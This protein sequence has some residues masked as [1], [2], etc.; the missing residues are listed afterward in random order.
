MASERAASHLAP[1]YLVAA[2]G[3][4][5][6]NFAGSLV[7]M[8][9]HRKAGA[10]GFVVNRPAP[11]TVARMLGSVDEALGGL[12]RAS[13]LGSDPVLVGGPVSPE[14]V[15]LLY[16]R[17]AAGEDDDAI[18]VGRHL[19]VASSRPVLEAILRG[20]DAGPVQ[21]FVG[22]A[23]WAPLQLEEEISQGSW[24]PLGFDED[25]A[26]TIPVPDRWSTAVRRL[27]LDPNGFLVGGG[28]AMA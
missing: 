2:P 23:G 10:M 16:R 17:G 24:V 15:W 4:R 3:L 9:G 27:G 13:A 12:A 5:D 14:Q 28:G 7:L 1:G 11:V 26:T 21:L 22:Y 20:A 18:R 25:L 6:P 8:T 19:A